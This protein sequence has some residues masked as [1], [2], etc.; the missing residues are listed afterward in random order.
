MALT[1]TRIR[2][3]KPARKP[4]KLTDS[5]GLHLEVRPTGSKLWRYRYRLRGKDKK[6]VEKLRENL[7]AL[8]EYVQPP[9]G[10]SRKEAEQRI[11]S[12]RLTLAEARTDRDKARGLVK[13]GI[14]PS[15]NREALR[16]AK[17]AEGANTF[18]VVAR[19]WIATRKSG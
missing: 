16:G 4:Y 7:F 18:E 15:K 14:H 12:G 3:A 9:Y 6:G 5:A 1:D 17:I 10:E 19:E 2:K 13:Q 11:Q 8:G